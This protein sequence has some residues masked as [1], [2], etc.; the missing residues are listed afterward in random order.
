MK[1]T[2]NEKCQPHTTTLYSLLVLLPGIKLQFSYTQRYTNIH[3]CFAVKPSTF[4]FYSRGHK[5]PFLGRKTTSRQT[6]LLT[7][8]F[9]ADYTKHLYYVI[10]TS[11]LCQNKNY[12]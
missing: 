6:Y 7:N 2:E 12:Y 3:D 1:P 9:R 10:P 4:L 8:P 5:I 11:L